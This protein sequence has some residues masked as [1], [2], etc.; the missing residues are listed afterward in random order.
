VQDDVITI[1]LRLPDLVVVGVK[2]TKGWIEVVARY[3]NEEAVCPRCG[4]G[5][6]QV[7]QWHVQRKRDAKLWGKE[8][9][10]AVLKRRFRCRRCRKV[11]MARDP[12]CGMRVEEEGAPT[13]AFEG[14]TYYFCSRGCRS[15]FEEDPQRFLSAVD[16]PEEAW[17]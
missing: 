6:W 3:R 7:H 14:Q 9:W 2:E 5:T 10:L 1:R 11:L 17:R 4:V 13:L 16:R 8:V 15:E 12:V